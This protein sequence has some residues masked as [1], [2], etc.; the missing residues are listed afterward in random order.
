MT[1]QPIPPAPAPSTPSAIP[2]AETG[3]TLDHLHP[4]QLRIGDAGVFAGS[5]AWIGPDP[6][7]MRI[8]VGYAG[9]LEDWWNGWAVWSATRDVIDAMVAEQHRLRR[10]VRQELAVDGHTGT[11]LQTHLDGLLPP[12]YLDGADLVVD[13]YANYEDDPLVRIS[14]GHDGRYIPMGWHWTWIAVE[15]A[16]CDRIVGHLPPP[17][18]R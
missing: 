9:R 3:G 18:T 2:T 17:P 8:P 16:R 1:H 14:P 15:P 5:W 10:L 13:E 7:T 4:D 12:M 11:D 6:E